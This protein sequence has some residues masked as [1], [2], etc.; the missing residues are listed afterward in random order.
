MKKRLCMHGNMTT[1]S[2]H[3]LLKKPSVTQ[4][5][6]TRVTENSTFHV[7]RSEKSVNT[8][9]WASLSIWLTEFS[10]ALVLWSCVTLGFS[11]SVGK[12]TFPANLKVV[13]Y[14]DGYYGG[15]SIFH[16]VLYRQ[17]LK[18]PT[19]FESATW[20]STFVS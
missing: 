19:V 14:M 7:E 9:D 13:H 5:Q 6:N 4:D 2:Q 12:R 3:T 10:V 11:N 1:F 16:Y 20:H 18:N 17:Y 15:H 8:R